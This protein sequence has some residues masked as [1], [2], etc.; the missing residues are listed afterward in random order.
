MEGP[1][2]YSQA[3]GLGVRMSELSRALAEGGYETHLFFAGDPKLPGVEKLVSGRLTYHRWC[4]WISRYHPLGVYDGEEGKCLDFERSLPPWVMQHVLLAQPRKNVV[5][6]SEEWHMANTT[7]ALSQLVAG[8][9][10]QNRT[11]FLWNANNTFGFHR[12]NWYALQKHATLTTVSRYMK[13][14]MLWRH[15]VPSWVIP[16]G[17]PK[18]WLS[19][20][21]LEKS[22]ELSKAFSCDL[23]LAKVGRF[24]PDKRWVM[25]IQSMAMLKRLGYRPKL[26]MR[27]GMESHGEEVRQ[28]A[29]T[30]GLEIASI[31]LPKEA[32]LPLLLQALKEN[33]KADIADLRFHISEEMQ[34][35]IYRGVDAVLANSRH[36]PFGL[37]GLEVMACGGVAITGNTGE[38]YAK[39]F[40]N[41][42]MVES[43]D[44]SE[45]TTYLASLAK[46][47]SL[48]ERLR[49]AGR[50][51]AKTFL[52][53]LVIEELKQK[54]I[55]L[56]LS[57][58]G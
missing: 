38:D 50:E 34:R 39:N 27:G 7:I 26:L 9:N 46:E 11:F 20:I 36:E 55:C 51:S 18:R 32:P 8:A 54:L 30:L 1:D 17:I 40:H 4:Q 48:G 31:K 28:I 24:D 13:Q 47:P 10:Q 5:I 33:P 6:L 23:L 3:G 35:V 42:L 52:W 57:R 41:A 16:N 37:V 2:L 19:P 56:R 22:R 49:I 21:P 58:E 29:W 25:A 14:E 53:D 45:L 12:I 15:H 44:P 43:D